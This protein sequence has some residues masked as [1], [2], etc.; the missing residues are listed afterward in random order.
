M[1]EKFD[2]CC[3]YDSPIHIGLD[4]EYEEIIKKNVEEIRNSCDEI[5][6]EIEDKEVETRGDPVVRIK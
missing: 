3:M 5:E 6:E 2:Y 4:D 1:T